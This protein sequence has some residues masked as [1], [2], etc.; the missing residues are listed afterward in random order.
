VRSS[1]A[2]HVVSRKPQVSAL[3]AVIGG[4]LHLRLQRSQAAG[5]PAG[6]LVVRE[7]LPVNIAAMGAVLEE[8][9]QANRAYKSTANFATWMAA[10][11]ARQP[12]L[13]PTS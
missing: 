3:R 1:S 5:S 10:D 9:H 12:K 13:R 4:P 8:P 2:A 7:D 11:H 6:L